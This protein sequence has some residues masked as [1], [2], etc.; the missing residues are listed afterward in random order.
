MCAGSTL[1]ETDNWV[2][3]DVKDLIGDINAPEDPPAVAPER[4]PP[5]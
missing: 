5:T 1:D 4:N 3:N 2:L